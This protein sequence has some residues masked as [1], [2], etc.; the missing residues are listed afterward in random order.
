MA[1]P[2]IFNNSTAGTVET[3]RLDE[4]ISQ[5]KIVAYKNFDN[6]INIGFNQER[7]PRA[8]A[9]L[10]VPE[11][12]SG[13]LNEENLSH[14]PEKRLREEKEMI[15]GV[16]FKNNKRGMIDEYQLDDLI[17]ADKIKSFCRSN[18]WVKVGRDPI[19]ERWKQSNYAGP[20]RRKRELP[21]D[22]FL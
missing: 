9:R 17:K 18:G 22:Y 16:I 13:K 14:P 10:P 12:K 6:W 7:E 2:V 1:I 19:R 21:P 20:E 3:Y 5:G 4:L 15:I 8:P 11:I